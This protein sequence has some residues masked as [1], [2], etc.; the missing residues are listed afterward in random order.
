M[1]FR[2]CVVIALAFHLAL[3][4][5][6]LK[7]HTRGQTKKVRLV[8]TEKAGI[9]VNS[10]KEKVLPEKKQKVQPSPHVVQPEKQAM[11]QVV[12]EIPVRKTPPKETKKQE[13]KKNVKPET[14]IA[15]P[16]ADIKNEIKTDSASEYVVPR[17]IEMPIREEP[18]RQP[19]AAEPIEVA[20]GSAE[21]PRFLK[22]ILPE[23]PFK[24]RR[25]GKTGVVILMLTIDAEGELIN[26][27]VLKGS[28][29]GFDEAAIVA[30]KNSLFAAARRNG[31]PVACKAVLPIRF[32]LR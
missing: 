30:I 32:K 14:S 8:V 5:C 21:G 28:G 15:S 7:E 31:S 20:F 23:Y 27:E 9:T 11:E 18:V 4:M 24:E 26:V 2:H 3:M 29:K 22:R 10:V 19:I 12:R 16:A 13:C 6:P 17:N 1:T 25:L